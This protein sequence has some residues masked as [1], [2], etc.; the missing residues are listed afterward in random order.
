[1]TITEAAVEEMSWTDHLTA[2]GYGLDLTLVFF[3]LAAWSF[4]QLGLARD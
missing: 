2:I 1:L 4:R 3:R